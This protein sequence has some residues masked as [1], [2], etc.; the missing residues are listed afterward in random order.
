MKTP[1]RKKRSNSART[2]ELARRA[3]EDWYVDHGQGD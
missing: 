1:N 3:S 2:L